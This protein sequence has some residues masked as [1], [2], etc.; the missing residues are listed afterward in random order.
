MS[1]GAL[2]LPLAALL[3]VPIAA[4]ALAV[5]AA[6]G[7][8]ALAVLV[9]RAAMA[10]AEAVAGG[11]IRLGEMVDARREA[12]IEAEQ[13]AALWQLAVAEVV[14]RNSQVKSLAGLA[15]AAGG[16]DFPVPPP[17][18]LAGASLCQIRDWCESTDK[19]LAVAREELERMAVAESVRQLA[20]MLPASDV[21]LTSAARALADGHSARAA[22]QAAAQ[23]AARATPAVPGGLQ[24]RKDEL[25]A[26]VDAELAK[27]D[28]QAR[29]GDRAKVLRVAA[30]A[31]AADHP[32]TGRTHADHLS[33]VIRV[34]NKAASDALAAARLLQGLRF[35]PLP[36][37]VGGHQVAPVIRSLEAVI[38]GERE[39]DAGLASEARERLSEIEAAG[40]QAYLREQVRQIMADNDWAVE[41]DFELL[42]AGADSLSFTRADWAGHHLHVEFGGADITYE[43]LRDHKAGDDGAAR[44][45]RKRCDQVRAAMD[46]AGAKLGSGGAAV[47]VL[48]N[49]GPPVRHLSDRPAPRS[50]G[51][52]RS[53]PVTLAHR[54]ESERP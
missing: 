7:V 16:P 29:P 27:L 35:E 48:A 14:E 11:I 4:A 49:D 44:L 42:G 47:R 53:R 43:T 19:W 51:T 28:P 34:A 38:A 12:Y 26:E 50:A 46:D 23:R 31:V 9:A 10:G 40:L 39:L 30:R 20:S 3:L 33:E 8:A 32:D 52:T 21:G 18:D 5:I 36:T 2:A 25:A 45:D 37:G 17:C 15:R 41:G 24:R 13:A 1:S 22:A 6:A 54:E